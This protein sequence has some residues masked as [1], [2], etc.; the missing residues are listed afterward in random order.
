MVGCLEIVPITKLGLFGNKSL[1]KLIL[2]LWGSIS[3]GLFVLY[4]GVSEI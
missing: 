4:I 2:V 1:S 3:V